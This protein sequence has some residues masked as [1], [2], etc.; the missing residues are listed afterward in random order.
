MQ[1]SAKSPIAKGLGVFSKIKYENWREFLVS[2][3]KG[4]FWA[5]FKRDQCSVTEILNFEA[6]HII[7]IMAR[8]KNIAS[9]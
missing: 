2:S 6:C 3:S 1:L 7:T 4:N 9:Y 5:F 8:K